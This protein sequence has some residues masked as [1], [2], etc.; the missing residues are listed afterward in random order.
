MNRPML[1][2]DMW[3][4]KVNLMFFSYYH[5]VALLVCRG[6]LWSPEHKIAI[7][8]FKSYYPFLCVGVALRST[9]VL[10]LITLLIRHIINI[11]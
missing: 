1:F 11:S 3:I 4:S 7:G 9:R 8:E 5:G 10:V 6:D 2:Y